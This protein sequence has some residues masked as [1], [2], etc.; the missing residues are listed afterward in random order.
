MKAKSFV[1]GKREVYQA[2]IQVKKNKGVG[3]IDRINLD[4]YE[5]NLKNNLYKLWNR[6]SS[7]VRVNI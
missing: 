4:K 5:L 1:I 3:G 7:G 2:F 6:M